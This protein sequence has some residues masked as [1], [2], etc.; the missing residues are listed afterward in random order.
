MNYECEKLEAFLNDELAD[1]DVLRFEAHVVKC[2]ACCEAVGQ[3]RWIDGLLRSTERLESE[4][5]P[6]AIRGRIRQSIMRRRKARLAACGLAAAAVVVIAAGWIF[7]LNRQARDAVKPVIA[8]AVVAEN[9]SSP[10]PSL[11]G[12]GTSQ[13]PRAVFVGGAD[14]FVA[15]V[16]SRHPNVT[17]V[18]IY[19]TYKPSLASKAN[20]EPSD[21]DPFNGG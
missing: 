9:E 8:Q 15:S 10:N 21:A 1:E 19:P 16:E 14:V 6:S 11:K 3:Q 13:P 18:R 7:V 20:V 4:P 12:R 5:A 2:E 17:I